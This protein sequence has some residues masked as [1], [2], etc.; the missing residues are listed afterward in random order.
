MTRREASQWLLASW[1]SLFLLSRGRTQNPIQSL[2]YRWVYVATNLL[3]TDNVKPLQ[4]LMHRA[5][6]AGYNGI[7]LAD[8]KFNLL[9]QMPSSYFQNVAAVK[10]TAHQLGI[11]IYPMVCPI[12]YSD[13]LLAHDPNLTEGL[14]VRDALFVV[15]NGHA[16]AAQDPAISLQNGD[17]EAAHGDTMT[18]WG[19]QDVPGVGT[20]ADQKIVHGGSQSLRMQNIGTANP[21]SGNGRIMQSVSVTP[22]HQYHIS[23]WIKT[24][25]FETPGSVQC[26]VLTP[27]GRSLS[28]AQWDIQK[29]QDWTQYHVVF[30]SLTNTKI[31]VYFGVW[32]G[33]GGT[34]WWDDAKLEDAGLLN[35]VRRD[36]CPLVV[37]SEDGTV[38]K[39]GQDFEMVKDDRMGVIPW[40]GEYEVYHAPPP[41]RLTAQSRIKDGQRLLV[42]FYH[43]VVINQGQVNVCFTDPKVYSLLQ[44]Q[45][46]RVHDLVQPPGFFLGHDEIRVANWCEACQSRHLTPGQMLA[47][48]V[49]RCAEMIRAAQPKAPIFLWSDMFDPSHNAHDNY[50]LV[51]GTW[52]GS[53][54]GLPKDAIIVN[55]NYDGRAKSLPW[56]AKL[57]HTQI[58]AGYY[59]GAPDSI[60]GWLIDAKK[61]SGVDGVMYTT[62]A[63]RYE[64]LEAFAH[65]AWGKTRPVT[66]C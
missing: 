19:F 17:F 37:R 53:W 11:A 41:I 12:G 40:P 38:Y 23:V 3:V 62:W 63:N 8:Y 43:A 14:P 7:A 52:A 51:N 28:Y 54:Q 4:D 56:F 18:G 1:L 65:A 58:L 6:K 31:S 50:Y 21:S 16:E 55:W 13:G 61:V 64:D 60:R 44:D 45:V 25:Q 36:G 49:R 5:Q 35:V 48:N 42:S 33:K 34:I 9:D 2:R 27:D 20:F 30:N 32:G 22:Y 66:S 15:E 10:A 26:A 59:D 24:D 39:E 29:T 47:D 57:G 46:K